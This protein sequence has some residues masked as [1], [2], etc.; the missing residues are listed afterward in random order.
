[1]E[2]SVLEYRQNIL[3]ML[4]DLERV[5]ST[6]ALAEGGILPASKVQEWGQVSEWQARR[7]ME[8]WALKGWLAKDASASRDNAFCSPPKPRIYSFLTW[9]PQT[10]KPLKP[11]QTASHGLKPS[12]TNSQT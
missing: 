12:K 8:T 1:M 9:T 7:P 5:L 11:D 3:P 6:R 4:S 10:T 2:Q